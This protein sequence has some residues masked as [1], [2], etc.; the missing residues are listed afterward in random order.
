MISRLAG[1]VCCLGALSLAGFSIGLAA[2]GGSLV[3]LDHIPLAVRD[4]EQ[5]S[6]TYRALGFAIKAGRPH[7]NGIRNAH[8][9]FRDGSGIELITAGAAVDSLTTRYLELLED[10]EGPAF[11]GL[12]AR[13]TDRLTAALRSG[14]HAFE[15]D[16]NITRPR[17]PDL[18]Y[19]F[20]VR[21]NRSATDRPEHFEHRN[22]ATALRAVWIAT[23]AGRELERLLL[24]LGGSSARRTVCAPDSVTAT[25]VSVDRGEV[26][27]LPESHQ[28]VAGRPIIGVSFQVADVEPVGRQLSSAG[29]AARIEAGAPGRVIVPP[30]ET[31]GVWLEFR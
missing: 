1:C 20:V 26:V 21:D 30:A 19:L 14:D 15:R 13:D 10:G 3:G 24:D 22:G 4:L 6:A 27:I 25:V 2:E 23:G 7:S 9:K 8:V 11:L 18:A 31:H 5:A 29:I 12:H 17:Q 28:V 16:G